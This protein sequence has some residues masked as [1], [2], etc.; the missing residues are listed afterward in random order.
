MF[1]LSLPDGKDNK[2]KVIMCELFG[3]H[4]HSST[5]Y[6]DQR[7]KYFQKRQLFYIYFTCNKLETSR[8]H[9]KRSTVHK[10][11]LLMALSEMQSSRQ[12]YTHQ[13][14]SGLG[15]RGEVP[16]VCFFGQECPLWPKNSLPLPH[17]VHL[18][19]ILPPNLFWIQVCNMQPTNKPYSLWHKNYLEGYESGL[20]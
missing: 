16:V 8:P 14:K 5:E 17:H 2:S 10:K 6:L 18:H 1:T 9:R 4:V 3:V 11:P 13:I 12:A 19:V 20:F 7:W 15:W